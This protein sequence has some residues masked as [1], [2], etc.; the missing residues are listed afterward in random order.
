MS[1]NTLQNDWMV[2][3]KGGLSTLFLKDPNVFVACDLLWYPVQGDPNKRIGPDVM[4]V[5]G[6][7]KGRRGAYKQWECDA[8]SS[9]GRAT[10]DRF[11]QPR[12]AVGTTR[13]KAAKPPVGS[14]QLDVPVAPARGDLD[15]KARSTGIT[16][17]GGE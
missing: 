1:D 8:G 11:H 6:R 10:H 14:M 15:L 3:I 13:G 9:P 4:V 5:F 12:G 7:P 16:K 2:T 17:L